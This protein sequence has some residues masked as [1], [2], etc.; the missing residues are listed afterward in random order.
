MLSIPTAVLHRRIV[1][2]LVLLNVLIY[3]RGQDNAWINEIHYDN[4][5]AD[6]NEAI[7][8]IVEN[9]DIDLS[10]YR[11]DLYSGGGVNKT[12]YRNETIDNMTLAGVEG[13]YSIFLWTVADIQNGPTDGVVLSYDGTVVQF[14]S[15]EGSFTATGGIANGLTAVDIGVSEPDNTSLNFSLQLSGSGSQYSDFVWQSPMTNTFGNVN[16]DQTLVDSGGNLPPS[17]TTETPSPSLPEA[18]EDVSVSAEVTDADGISWVTL[19]YDTGFPVVRDPVRTISMDNSFGSTYVTSA[20]IPAQSNG[21]KVYFEIEAT[22]ANATPATAVSDG[23]SYLVLDENTLVITEIMNNPA[24]VADS[25]GEYFEVYNNASVAIDLEGFSFRDLGN[26][27]FNLTNSGLGVIVPANDFLV[28]GVNADGT[29][30]G[31][32]VVDYAYASSEFTLANSEDEII[33][34]NSYGDTIDLVEYGSG[35]PKPTGAGIVYAGLL[36]EDNNNESLWATASTQEGIA[37]DFGSPGI[38][39]K[40]QFINSVFDLTYDSGLWSPVAPDASTSGS[41]ALILNGDTML[42]P[43]VNLAGLQIR[44]GAEATV[45]AG[46]ILTISESLTIF[47]DLTFKSDPSGDAELGPLLNGASE[48]AAYDGTVN[49][50]A[51]YSDSRS[52]RMVTSSLN[53]TNTIYSQWQE[54][55]NIAATGTH[56]TGAKSTDDT[57]IYAGDGIVPAG[58]ADSPKGGISVNG[59]DFT[60]SGNPSMF[61]VDVPSQAFVPIA[62]TIVFPADN[63]VAGFPYFMFIRGDRDQVNLTV[64]DTRSAT[65]LETRGR[66]VHGEVVQTVEA[67]TDPDKDEDGDP[68][69]GLFGMFGN[70][71]QAAVD[72][73][74]VLSNAATQNVETNVV[75]YYD[76]TLAS[77]QIGV[78]GAYVTVDLDPDD[79]GDLTDNAAAILASSGNADQFLQPGQGF[80]VQLSSNAASSVIYNED[81]KAPGNLTQTRGKNSGRDQSILK[82]KL[83]QKDKFENNG[84]EQDGF[85]LS[86]ADSFSNEVTRGDAPKFLNFQESIGLNNDGTLLAIEKR[87]F[88]KEGQYIDLFI[89]NLKEES[90]V[91]QFDLSNFP[92]ELQPV[93]ID[94]F[95]AKRHLIEHNGINL[96]PFKVDNTRESKAEDRFDLYFDRN[97]RINGN[98]VHPIY[99][100]PNPFRDNVINIRSSVLTNKK[101]R[102]TCTDAMGKV[103]FA[104]DSDIKSDNLTISIDNPIAIGIYFLKIESSEITYTHKIIKNQ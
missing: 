98:L 49:T 82:V 35:W 45:P 70:P 60:R 103:I 7:E 31:G 22:D 11:L 84:T 52:Y 100:Y 27:L 18:S 42:D 101:V 37:P 47:G 3:A 10:K 79:N 9:P 8:V 75:Y 90:Y 76:P 51:Y 19:Y 85:V 96:V 17:I 24:A 66:L 29:T 99:V 97:L 26:N 93:I 5:G 56:I 81:D 21:T 61:T 62:S 88:P 32:I 55:G 1:S 95:S 71:Y 20:S 91:L 39:G 102:I 104:E 46:G 28:F 72:L 6:F 86:F 13:N 4:Q 80:Q 73:T 77:T 69:T 74:Q 87:E 68:A 44:E 67:F 65:T 38:E 54:N 48:L 94:N 53:S 16:T 83:F 59:F 33:F 78:G 43:I 41:N 58:Q 57:Q 25:A 92:D 12:S 64:N 34:E 40:E 23:L 50:E 14:L 89:E 63:L 15:Y 30:N 2:L 36:S